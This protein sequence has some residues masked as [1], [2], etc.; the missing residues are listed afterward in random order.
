[1]T[2]KLPRR[3]T[4]KTLQFCADKLLSVDSKNDVCIFELETGRMVGSYAPPGHITALL[5]DPSLDYALIGLQHG[6]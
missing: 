2:L 5:T 3:A 6:G 4:V 1:M